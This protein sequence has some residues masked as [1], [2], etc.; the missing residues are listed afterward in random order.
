MREEIRQDKDWVIRL[1]SLP[2][3]PETFY[4]MTLMA[5][6]DFQS[7][8]Q[9]YL[10]LEDLRKKLVS[11][12]GSLDAFDDIIGLRR[13]Y[14]EP[15]LPEIDREFRKL[16]AQMRLRLEQREHVQRRL[17][18]MLIAPAAGPPGDGGRAERGSGARAAG[19]LAAGRER[20]RTGAA[21]E[22]ASCD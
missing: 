6:N 12:Q 1:R 10:D 8:L 11:W 16:D 7:A 2:D 21:A 17:Q 14:Y 20:T 15:R 4:L 13:G 19:E 3:A 9:N 22:L 5:S 18:H